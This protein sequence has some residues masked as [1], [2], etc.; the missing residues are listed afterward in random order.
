MRQMRA[1]RATMRTLAKLLKVSEKHLALIESEY[2][3]K[4]QLEPKSIRLT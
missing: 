2:Y 1:A 3:T 4:E